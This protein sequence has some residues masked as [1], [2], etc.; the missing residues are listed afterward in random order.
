MHYPLISIII[1]VQRCNEMLNECLKIC[2][3]LDYP[4]LEILVLPDS[5]GSPN[6]F[7][8]AGR[9]HSGLLRIIPTGSMGPAEKRN[10]GMEEAG[11]EILAFLDDDTYPSKDWLKNSLR[12]FEKEDIAAVGGPAVTPEN[13]D[14]R[15]KAGGAI[16]SSLLG[17]GT[18]RYRYTPTKERMVDDFPSCNFIVR[19]SVLEELGGFKTRFWPGEDTAIC[20]DITRKLGKKIVYD[21]KVLIYHHRRRLFLPHLKQVTNYALHRGYF[22]KRLPQTSLRLSYFLPSLLTLGLLLGWTLGFIHPFFFF[23]FTVFLAIYLVLTLLTGLKHLPVKKASL[24]CIGIVLTHLSYG[25]WFV[26]GLFSH[27]LREER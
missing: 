25:I 15:Q 13:D 16:F 20:L 10:R 23:L 7:N 24:V 12:H 14:L 22:A 11:G 1:P 18:C 5:I 4:H 2:V 26:K 19:K 17:G 27:K 3:K 8:P 9:L 21:P 6:L